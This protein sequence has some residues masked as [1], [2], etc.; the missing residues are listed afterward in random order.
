MVEPIKLEPVKAENPGTAPDEPAF[1]LPENPGTSLKLETPSLRQAMRRARVEA[2]DHTQGFA[3]L[4][5]AELARLEILSE[6]LRSVLDQVPPDVDLFDTGVVPG[7]H[8][9]L[10]VDMI[11]FVQMGRDKRTYRFLQDR[12]DGR[13]TL[14]ESTE[15]K[16]ILK[17]IT[18]YIARR[19]VEREKALASVE[20][21]PSQ[22][23]KS[24]EA[25]APAPKLIESNA[26]SSAKLSATSFSPPKPSAAPQSYNHAHRHGWFMRTILFLIEF[27][28][29]ASLTALL[30]AV[31]FY[32][33]M[34]LS[35]AV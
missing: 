2:A 17:A 18:D 11:A 21:V 13:V 27:L 35:G 19:L 33:Y 20:D 8:P 32:V 7:D 14:A 1:D 34:R 24:I 30:I 6:D 9:R 12:R 3:D 4:R 29:V 15:S 23:P 31:G 26:D 16:V 5:S 25:K 22:W 28:F 10:F